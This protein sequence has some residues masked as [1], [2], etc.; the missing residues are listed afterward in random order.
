MTD[1]DDGVCNGPTRIDVIADHHPCSMTSVAVLSLSEP[2][3][4]ASYVQKLPFPLFNQ[5]PFHLPDSPAMACQTES[6]VN[7]PLRLQCM[8]V[9]ELAMFLRVVVCCRNVF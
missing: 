5:S 2:S 6:T 3:E 8:Q 7:L 4:L 1:V 9:S